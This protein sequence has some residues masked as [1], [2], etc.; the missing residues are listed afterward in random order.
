MVRKSSSDSLTD[1]SKYGKRPSE[2]IKPDEAVG[3]SVKKLK[4]GGC[5]LATA[6]R[7]KEVTELPS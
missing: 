5:S 7:R 1:K 2:I 4:F 3:G 6:E